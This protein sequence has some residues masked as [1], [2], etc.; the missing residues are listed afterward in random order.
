MS[1]SLAK[2]LE[3]DLELLSRQLSSDGPLP[4]SNIRVTASVVC[5]KWLIER[6]LARLFHEL[7]AHPTLLALDTSEHVSVINKNGRFNFYTSGGVSIDGRP[8]NSIYAHRDQRPPHINSLLAVPKLKHYTVSKFLSRKCTYIEGVWIT[9]EDVIR[10]VANKEGGVHFDTKRDKFVERS[11]DRAKEALW[12]GSDVPDP[13]PDQLEVF[14]QVRKPTGAAWNCT[15]I[16]ML[17]VAQGLLNLHCNG[18]PVV[19]SINQGEK[20]WAPLQ[21]FIGSV[22]RLLS[23]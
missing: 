7:R 20:T 11:I 17:S 5:R 19:I 22:S 6:N 13:W 14:L 15:H 16:E 9:S 3:D 23:R 4:L 21:S 8:L 2:M 1:T 10:Y 12:I 18:S